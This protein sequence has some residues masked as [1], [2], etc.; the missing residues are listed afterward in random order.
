VIVAG[1]EDR[2]VDIDA[3]SARLHGDVPQ[4]SFHRVPENGHMIHQTATDVVM[5]A[6]NEV[7]AAEQRIAA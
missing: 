2:L 7:A 5:S 4:S 6:I 3:Q 1:E